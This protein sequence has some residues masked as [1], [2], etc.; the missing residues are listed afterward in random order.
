MRLAEKEKYE[1]IREKKMEKIEIDAPSSFWIVEGLCQSTMIT[2]RGQANAHAREP[3]E[4][5]EWA[6]N[7]GKGE[8]MRRV[9]C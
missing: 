6:G 5:G 7:R 2:L 3:T 4:A 8:M 9:A 1:V